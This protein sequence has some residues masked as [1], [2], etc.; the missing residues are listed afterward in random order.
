MNSDALFDM[1]ETIQ[2]QQNNSKLV[3]QHIENIKEDILYMGK[4]SPKIEGTSSPNVVRLAETFA[5]NLIQHTKEQHD[6][7]LQRVQKDLEVVLLNKIIYLDTVKK[8]KQSVINTSNQI[9]SKSTT[10][11]QQEERKKKSNYKQRI[12]TPVRKKRVEQAKGKQ[13]VLQMLGQVI[14]EQVENQMIIQQNRDV[15]DIKVVKNEESEEDEECD[16]HDHDDHDSNESLNYEDDHHH[17]ESQANAQ[18]QHHHV[19]KPQE[20]GHKH[21]MGHSHQHAH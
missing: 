8:A 7:E 17:H 19:E 1:I 18:Y 12:F 20:V 6:K 11:K 4:E 5:V 3:K 13:K 14:K 9:I 15:S 2:E 10:E 21:E 16:G